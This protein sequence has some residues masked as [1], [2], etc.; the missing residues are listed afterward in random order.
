MKKRG[1]IG[2]GRSSY[3]G[4]CPCSAILSNLNAT[5]HR[6]L[7]AERF[8]SFQF[9]AARSISA[10]L[11]RAISLASL[12]ASIAAISATLCESSSRLHLGSCALALHRLTIR[13]CVSA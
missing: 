11:L 8:S 6:R 1:N 7:D 10:A 4:F 2:E 13:K 9:S 5:R 12:P 3:D